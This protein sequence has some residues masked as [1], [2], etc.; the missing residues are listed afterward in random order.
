MLSVRKS[1]RVVG[2]VCWWVFVALVVV[3]LFAPGSSSRWWVYLPALAATALTVVGGRL[4]ARDIQ[5][6]RREPVEVAVPVRGR[7]IA[8]N[9]PA[10]KVPSH[11]THAY[12]QS[13]AI[14]LVAEPEPGS[15]PSF[16]RVWPV[17]RG[18]GR[19]PGFGEPVLA[20]ADAT[21]VR[22][23]DGRR[24]HLSRNS[25]LGLVYLL[26]VEGAVRD[27]AGPGW[28][29]GNHVVL[30]LGNGAY[31]LYAH[32]RRGSVPVRAG[33][34]V[35]AGRVIGRCGN[36]GNSSEPH[37]HF[38]LMDHPDPDVATGI[39]FRWQAT[40]LPPNGAAFHP[41]PHHPASA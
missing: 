32:L 11:G 7:W 1:T 35:R 26:T 25:L 28:L 5:A 34:H 21:V 12:G 3:G 6:D 2:R 40:P 15:R 31:A 14:D 23:A 17:F 27:M 4:T 24:D 13:Y 20:V 41:A 16:A 8:L 37:V 19:F 29:L 18:A 22:A 36:S 38:Q 9:S 30:D 39:P 10:T 33:D